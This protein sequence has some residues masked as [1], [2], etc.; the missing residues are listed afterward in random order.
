MIHSSHLPSCDPV[1]TYSQ[2]EGSQGW[3]V[4]DWPHFWTFL[5]TGYQT[6]WW[7]SV[8]KGSWTPNEKSLFYQ[9]QGTVWPTH[10][11]VVTPWMCLRVVTVQLPWDSSCPEKWLCPLCWWL[12]FCLMG[13]LSPGRQHAPQR[14]S[15]SDHWVKFNGF[16][17]LALQ[18]ILLNMLYNHVLFSMEWLTFK[19]YFVLSC[20]YV[21]IWHVWF[22][23]MYVYFYTRFLLNSIANQCKTSHGCHCK[24]FFILFCLAFL[25]IHLFSWVSNAWCGYHSIP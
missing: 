7:V 15:F 12:S 25:L 21:S 3:R 11:V 24:I 19:F 14:L 23:F 6:G 13:R 16:I 20:T 4:Q 2:V 5:R 9:G 17:L 8:N 18:S 22:F 1:H 10:Q